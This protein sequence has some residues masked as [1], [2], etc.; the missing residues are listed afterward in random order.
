MTKEEL[1]RKIEKLKA[2]MVQSGNENGL[3]HPTT[4]QISQ[5]LDELINVYMKLIGKK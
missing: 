1:Q 5:E 2:D 3:A 4:I